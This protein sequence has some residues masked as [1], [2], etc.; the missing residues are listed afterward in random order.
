[1]STR[2]ILGTGLYLISFVFKNCSE[3]TRFQGTAQNARSHT[4]GPGKNKWVTKKKTKRHGRGN[5]IVGRRDG[6]VIGMGG[7]FY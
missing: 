6:E 7:G 2:R 5:G 3:N 4:A 1:M